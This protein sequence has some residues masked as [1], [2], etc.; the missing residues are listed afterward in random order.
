L[1]PEIVKR[2]CSR[3]RGRLEAVIDAE[4]GFIE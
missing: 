2:A 1:S 4:G 3:F